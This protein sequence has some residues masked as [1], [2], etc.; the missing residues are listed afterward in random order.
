MNPP[1]KERQHQILTG[2]IAISLLLHA[3]FIAFLQNHSLWF[4]SKNNLSQKEE[5]LSSW[6]TLMEKKAKDEILAE[7]FA[8]SAEKKIEQRTPTQQK[9]SLQF[10]PSSVASPEI[11]SFFRS[12]PPPLTIELQLLS[13]NDFLSHY[14]PLMTVEPPPFDLLA[15]LPKDLLLSPAEKSF[16][17]LPF[18]P[19]QE[20]VSIHS[21]VAQMDPVLKTPDPTLSTFFAITPPAEVSIPTQ[22]PTI[23]LPS[24]PQLPTLEELE[25]VNLSDSFDSELVFLPNEEGKGYIFALTLIPKPDLRLPK[26]PQHFTFL[27][28]RSNSI[29]RE[30]LIGVKNAIHKALDELDPEDSFNIVAFDSKVDKLFPSFV[31]PDAISISKAKAFL[32]HIDLGSFFSTADLYKPLLLT[33]PAAVDDSEIFTALLFT[34]GETLGKKTLQRALL[35]D[36]TFQN[37]GKVSL[38]ALGMSG[39]LHNGTLD[40][41]CAFN[42]GRF[43]S[44]TTKRGLKRKLLKLVKTLGNPVAKNLALKAIGKVPGTQIEMYPSNTTSPHLYLEQ[45]YVIMGSTEHLDDFILFAQGK[46]KDRWIHIKKKISFINAK[47]GALPLKTGWALQ[48]AYKEYLLYIGD[49]D[50]SHLAEARLLLEPFEL[51]LA[52]E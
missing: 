24:L 18:A 30:R 9:E 33:T 10:L 27:I 6:S 12:P 7:A 17:T 5:D 49:H 39:D 50:P 34:N 4:Y 1:P 41:L 13:N 32:D 19:N 52:F 38:F 3:C 51:Q 29:Q 36:W 20:A 16:Q 22:N 31:R 26:I 35:E 48:K 46:L 23:P 14:K 45:P 2:S 44:A 43:L 11:A 8:F 28:D 40:A 21:L 37:S 25:T 15:K 42:K 47:K